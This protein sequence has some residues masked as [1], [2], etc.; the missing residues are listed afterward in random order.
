MLRRKRK[1]V[2][3]PGIELKFLGHGARIFI[4]ISKGTIDQSSYRETDSLCFQVFTVIDLI[5]SC[6]SETGTGQ[7]VA[8]LHDR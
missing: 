5:I 6:S 3:L 8:Q 1:A 4:L 7:Q 2:A